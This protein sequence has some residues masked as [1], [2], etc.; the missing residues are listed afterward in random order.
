MAGQVVI[1][2][3]TGMEDQENVTVAFLVAVGAA[4]SGVPT[5]MFQT[6]EAARLALDGVAAGIACDARLASAHARRTPS[7]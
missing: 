1:S 6:Q 4:E 5:V 7:P 2:L 3:T